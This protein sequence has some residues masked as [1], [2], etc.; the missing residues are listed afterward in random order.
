VPGAHAQRGSWEV[1]DPVVIDTE[2]YGPVLSP[3]GRWVAGVADI[4]TRQICVWKV[5][6]GEQ[7]CNEESERVAEASI[8]WSPD[9]RT[10]AFSQNGHEFDSDVFALDVANNSLTNLTEDDVDDLK[11]RVTASQFV[12][13]DQWPVWSID[14]SEIFFLRILNP[15]DDNGQRTIAAGRIVVETGQ[16][17]RGPEM[18]TE[19]PLALIAEAV[20]VVTPPVWLPDGMAVFALRGGQDITGV[21]EVD[22]AGRE[23]TRIAS[24]PEIPVGKTP[25]L[26]G[27]TPDGAYLTFYWLWEDIE[28]EDGPA[29]YGYLDRD[30]GELVPIEIEVPRGMVVA[31]PPR[32]SPDGQWIVYGITEDEQTHQDSTIVIADLATGGTIDIADGVSLQFWES[33]TGI[34]WS[35]ENQLVVPLDDGRFE[36]ITLTEG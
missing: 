29:T 16:V 21:W 6:N 3:D 15:R 8:A 5:S 13:Y 10:V 24:D 11:A 14:G 33:V 12:I 20:G 25:I 7:R 17:L 4:D 23:F 27:A 1:A 31:A 28:L 9:S 36:V 32:L 34:D 30:T 35:A 19:E 22:P 26:T 18:T 2:G